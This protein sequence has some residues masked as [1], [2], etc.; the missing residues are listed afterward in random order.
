M[1]RS[2]ALP[3]LGNNQLEGVAIRKKADG[4]VIVYLADDGAEKESGGVFPFDFTCIFETLPAECQCCVVVVPRFNVLLVSAG[5]SKGVYG[6]LKTVEKCENTSA[7]TI[8]V[9]MLLGI[10]ALV[11]VLE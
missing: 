9:H 6:A 10:A 7:G 1:L 2:F 5:Y 8:R 11:G 3:N 4:Q